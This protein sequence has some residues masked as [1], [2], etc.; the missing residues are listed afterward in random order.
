MNINQETIVKCLQQSASI[1]EQKKLKQ[2]LIEKPSHQSYFKQIE[3]VWKNADLKPSEVNFDVSQAWN[4]INSKISS[5]EEVNVVPMWSQPWVRVAASVVLVLGIGLGVY[6]QLATPSADSM[7]MVEM[8]SSDVPQELQLPDGSRVTLMPFSSV[9][10]SSDF[11]HEREIMLTGGAFFEVRKSNDQPFVVN[12]EKLEV[13]V[14]GTKFLVKESDQRTEV[15]VEEGSVSVSPNANNGEK[16]LTAEQ[17]VYLDNSSGIIKPIAITDNILSWK[18]GVLEFNNVQLTKVL[19]D[20]GT[21]YNVSIRLKNSNIGKCHLT[22]RLDNKSIDEVLQV[23][24]LVLNVEISASSTN[25]YLISGK[26]C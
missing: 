12:V 22:S 10:Y 19:Q 2:W 1:D 4:T 15:F 16:I 20:I 17:G 14:L 18:S 5:S 11:G 23:L 9:S 25:E 26:G 3:A 13:T 21:H 8:T 24:E 6:F 7:A